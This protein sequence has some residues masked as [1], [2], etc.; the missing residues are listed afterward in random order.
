[1]ASSR[2]LARQVVMQSIFADDFLVSDL[3]K[4]NRIFDSLA[5]EYGFDAKTLDFSRAMLRG[6]L[7]HRQELDETISLHAPSFPLEKI[8][9][10]DLAVLRL[11]AYELFYHKKEDV[12]AVVAINEAIEI[13]KEFGGDNSAKFVNGVL[14]AIMK[15]EL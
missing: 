6:I 5:F 8:A 9:K 14:N 2:H 4:A 15:S 12:P 7:E 1:M 10:V 13:A 11:G 3:E